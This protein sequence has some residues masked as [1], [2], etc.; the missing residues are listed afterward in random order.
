M[1]YDS[2]DSKPYISFNFQN[3]SVYDQYVYYYW[4]IRK[5]R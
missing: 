1:L 4:P 3:L 5:I 2:F